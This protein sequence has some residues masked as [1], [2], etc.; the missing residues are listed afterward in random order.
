MAASAQPDREVRVIGLLGGVAS[1]K[2]S[3][4]RIL[5]EAGWDW[6]D[7]DRLARRALEASEI[8]P[9]LRELFGPAVESATG[10]VDRS[11]LAKIVFSDP[12]MR[13][14]L[15]ALIHPRVRVEIENL[16]AR[17]AENGAKVVLDIPLLLEN[18]WAKR[19]DLLVFVDTPEEVRRDR[20]ISRG[21]SAEDWALREKAQASIEAKRDAAD[22]IVC[23]AGDLD[24]LRAGLA[25]L[26]D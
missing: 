1:G 14:A 22:L 24:Q 12:E 6:V 19:C 5:V 25:S 7:A 17:A 8:R 21:M 2:S 9:E 3:V 20:A 15:E 10:E 13:E 26:L 4:A 23:N 16:L 18:G 11:H